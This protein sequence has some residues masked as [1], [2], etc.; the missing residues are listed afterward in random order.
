MPWTLSRG[1]DH[2][3]GSSRPMSARFRRRWKSVVARA[4]TASAISAVRLHAASGRKFDTT[5]SAERRLCDEIPHL[6][7]S[8]D[9]DPA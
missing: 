9:A 2:G 3:I 7:D 1:I 8:L 5:Q 4:R 6:P